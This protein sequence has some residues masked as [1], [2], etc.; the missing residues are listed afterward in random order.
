MNMLT[1]RGL[2]GSM[3]GVEVT[4][5]YNPKE[6]GVEQFIPWRTAKWE[7]PDFDSMTVAPRTMS[8]ELMFDTLESGT[9]IQGTVDTIHKLSGVDATLKRPSKV[10]VA[11]GAGAPGALPAFEGVI[12]S[13]GVKYTMFNADG[14]PLR[15]TVG[16]R[17]IEARKVSIAA[18]K[19]SRAPSS[20]TLSR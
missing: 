16:L 8:F 14:T 11:W 17:V 1:I 13:V 19:K 20:T 12:E 7:G 18:K 5:Q 4:A 6:V 2:E 10:R 3:S 9:P 15:A